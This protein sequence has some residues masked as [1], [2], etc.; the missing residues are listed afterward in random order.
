MLALAPLS[1]LTSPRVL[2][3]VIVIGLGDVLVLTR[4]RARS[5]DIGFGLWEIAMP[6]GCRA[7]HHMNI[8]CANGTGDYIHPGDPTNVYEKFRVEMNPL[9]GA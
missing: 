3:F 4:A 8:G 6:M 7:A 1:H 9:L 5:G 2:V